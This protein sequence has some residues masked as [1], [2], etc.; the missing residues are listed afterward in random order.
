MVRW[1]FGV[2]QEPVEGRDGLDFVAEQ[3]GPF[4]HALVAGDD[5]RGAGVAAVDQLEEPVRVG[6]FQSHVADLVDDQNV[7]SLVMREL[8]AQ[9]A[10]L[11]GLAQFSQ[12]VVEGR[13]ADEVAG[14]ECFHRQPHR[15]VCLPDAGWAQVSDETLF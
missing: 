14:A 13:I 12:D 5:H 15:Q 6:V 4:G 8:V 3:L 2:V 1:D 7:G 10:E 11:V 9:R